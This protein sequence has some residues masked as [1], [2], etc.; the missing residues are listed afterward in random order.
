[1]SSL[2]SLFLSKSCEAKF[3]EL[4]LELA[5]AVEALNWFQFERFIKTFTNLNMIFSEEWIKHRNL[6]LK[7]NFS[8]MTTRDIKGCFNVLPC[9]Q[10]ASDVEASQ[11]SKLTIVIKWKSSLIMRWI[12]NCKG[13]P[14]GDLENWPTCVSVTEVESNFVSRQVSISINNLR[15]I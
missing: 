13:W 3:L 11:L 9:C 14:G 1:M 8:I 6:S 10:G 7:L 4:V 15:E 5:V 12:Q 2:A